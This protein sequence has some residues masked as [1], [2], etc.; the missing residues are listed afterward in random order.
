MSCKVVS[1]RLI[2]ESVVVATVPGSGLTGS[3]V[4]L[5]ATAAT[6]LPVVY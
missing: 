6:S 1:P 4:R 5:P 3:L 2:T